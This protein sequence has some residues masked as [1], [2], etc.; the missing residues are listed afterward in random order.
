MLVGVLGSVKD[1]IYMSQQRS[2][3][4]LA[5]CLSGLREAPA[6]VQQVAGGWMSDD[7]DRQESKTRGKFRCETKDLESR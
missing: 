5:A 6:P 2:M 4:F 1:G 3:L 7:T